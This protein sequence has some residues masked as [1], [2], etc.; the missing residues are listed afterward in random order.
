M[1]AIAEFKDQTKQDAILR[2]A[3]EVFA[4]EGFANTDV[5]AIADKAGVGK[6]TVYRYFGN[7][8]DLFLACA[9]YGMKRLEDHIYSAIDGV[10][11]AIAV[12]RRMAS[13]YGQFFQDNPQIVEI[14]IQER[15][16]FR[17]SIPDTHLVYRRKNQG[18]LDDVLKRGIKAGE[19]RKINVRGAGDALANAL[20]GTVVCGCLEGSSRNLR[21]MAEQA[22]DIFLNG[23]LCQPARQN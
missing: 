1:T 7:K 3:T 21:R 13:A 17:G 8:S 9:E 20:Y 22:V 14:L 12:V 5:Q 19:I 2:H 16:A 18:V 11:G 4:T 15:A 23:I 6:G 10:D